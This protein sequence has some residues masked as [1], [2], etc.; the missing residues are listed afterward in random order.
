MLAP[1]IRIHLS[2]RT[3]R[4]RSQNSL[5]VNHAELH[6]AKLSHQ[7]A[8]MAMQAATI[9]NQAQ[10]Q[11]ALHEVLTPARL[12]STKGIEKSKEAVAALALLTGQHKQMFAT[13]MSQ[14]AA[15]I[16]SSVTE[17][18]PERQEQLRD[19]L[20]ESVNWNLAAQTAF[21]EGR[22]IWTQSAMQLLDLVENSREHLEFDGERLL[23]HSDELL[24]HFNSLVR[25]LDE[26]HHKEVS[27]LA[28]RQA[29]I[30]AAA[31]KLQGAQ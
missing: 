31:A 22:E 16:L 12:S 8:L 25:T 15:Q 20:V 29:R 3:A 30:A 4:Y 7:V 23:F 2:A 24:D 6:L 13:F 26:V 5:S 14:A 10:S 27:S 1:N 19:S 18:V 17:L 28:E 9:Y 11:L 21:Y